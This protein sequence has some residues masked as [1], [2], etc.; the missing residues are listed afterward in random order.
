MLENE[1]VALS[2]CSVTVVREPSKGR[3]WVPFSEPSQEKLTL[4]GCYRSPP[5]RFCR[6]PAPWEFASVYLGVSGPGVQPLLQHRPWA[7]ETH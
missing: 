1:P 7:G 2:L 6:D 3:E 5:W 4:S